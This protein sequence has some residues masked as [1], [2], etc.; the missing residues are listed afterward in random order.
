MNI[1]DAIRD[2]LLFRPHFEEPAKGLTLETWASWLTFLSALFALDIPDRG[3]Y[4][5]ATGRK[6]LPGEPFTEAWLCVGRRGGKSF[7][8]ALIA[9]YLACFRDWKQHIRSGERGTVMIIA[10]DRYQARTIFWYVEALF[11][12]TP[13]LKRMVNPK[14][15][16]KDRIGLKNMVQIEIR[17]SNYRTVRGYTIVAALLDE[18]AFWP[19]DASAN[20]DYEIIRALTPGMATIPGAMLLAASSP[21]ARRGALYKAYKDHWGKEN[22]NILVWKADTKTMNPAIPDAFLKKEYDKDPLSAAAEFGAEFRTDVEMLLSQE[23]IDACVRPGGLEIPPV[24]KV[25]YRAFVDPSGGSNDSMTLGVGHLEDE[26]IVIDCLRE[27]KPPFSPESVVQEFSEVLRSYG[28]LQV[29][30]DRYGGEWPRERFRLAGVH[31][32]PSEKPKSDLY[33]EML[34]VVNMAG[35][36]LPQNARLVAQMSSLERKTAR[37]GK[38]SIDHP[39]GGHDDLA[40]VVAGVI[41]QCKKPKFQPRVW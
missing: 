20:P 14:E 8:L 38:D 26:L 25:S 12:N 19:T 2:E 23:V 28:C 30:G 6:E 37:G 33:R 22:S 36:D 4:E 29:V 39:P 1:T 32:K 5:R 11:D 41:A 24:G 34:P 9:T 17:T 10:A 15:R 31:Y 7:V 35:V 16:T 40:N 13:A 3:L 21:Y 18:I 27:R